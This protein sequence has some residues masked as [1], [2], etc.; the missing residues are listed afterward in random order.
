MPIS[1]TPETKFDEDDW[2]LL[3]ADIEQ[4]NV[5]PVVGPDLLIRGADPSQ[6]L[7]GYLASELIQRLGIDPSRLPSPSSDLLDLCSHIESRGQVAGAIRKAIHGANWPIPAPLAQLAAISGFDLYVS[8][9]FD[10]LLYDAVRQ[11]RA[12]AESRIYGLKRPHSEADIGSGRLTAPVVFQMFGLLDAT[13]DCALSEEEI[14]QFSQRLQDPGYRPARVFDLLAR[15]NLLFLGCGF[16]GWLGRFFRRVLKVSGDLRDQGL[17]ADRACAADPGY[18]LFLERQG[19]KLWLQDS[20]VDFVAELD[21]RWRQKHQPDESA[22][23]FLSYAREDVADARDLAEI[24]HQAGIPVWFDWNS[25]QAG[26]VWNQEIVTGI[27]SSRVFI[28]LIS[29]NSDRTRRERFVHK[30]WDLASN[31]SGKRICP[32]LLDYTAIPVEF[33]EFH[34]RKV[35]ESDELVRDVKL[36]L[37]APREGNP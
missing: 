13:A 33:K 27:Q 9:T 16:P 8:T 29:R 19:A 14:L 36:F 3:I 1:R 34:T 25:L 5:V 7:H 35:G 30:E 26:E 23:V 18:V 28:P 21:R 32:V 17:F 4:H 10:S 6:T 2:D 37:N 11:A 22:P 15:R 12:G 20:G 24:F 31:M